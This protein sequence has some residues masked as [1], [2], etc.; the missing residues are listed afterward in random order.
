MIWIVLLL[1]AVAVV[2][3]IAGFSI[4]NELVG[5]AAFMVGIAVILSLLISLSIA[6]LA[7]LSVGADLAEVAELRRVAQSVDIRAS[8]DVAGKVAD[9]NVALRSAQWWNHTIVGNPFIP[10]EWDTVQVIAMPE[11]PR[12]HD[13]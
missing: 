3:M 1:V 12:A 5:T 9:F 11:R 2:L 10:D 7:K 8:E 13:D 4:E 6:G